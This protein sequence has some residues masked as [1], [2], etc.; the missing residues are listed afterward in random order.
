MNFDAFISSLSLAAPPSHLSSALRALWFD[1]NGLWDKAHN[2]IQ[3]EDDEESTAVHA[4][5]HRKEG[6]LWNARYWYRNAKRRE[7]SGSLE[8][9]WEVLAREFL[10]EARAEARV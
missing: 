7:F 6:D 4:Y 8:L 3:H 2:E 10:R 5:L 9:E 1:R